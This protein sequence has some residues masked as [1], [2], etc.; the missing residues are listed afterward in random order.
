MVRSNYCLLSPLN[1]SSEQKSGGKR[2]N[3]FLTEM[4]KK[5]ML[6]SRIIYCKVRKYFRIFL[7]MNYETG[8][9]LQLYELSFWYHNTYIS[10]SMFSWNCK[11]KIHIAVL[12]SKMIIMNEPNYFW[13]CSSIFDLKKY[14]SSCCSFGPKFSEIFSTILL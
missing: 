7:I 12:S 8:W 14:I 11:N 5:K 10:L 3:V 6:P 13:I 9:V 4:I 2:S 1:K